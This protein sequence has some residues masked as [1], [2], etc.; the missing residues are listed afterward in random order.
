MTWKTWLSD[1]FF[2][3]SSFRNSRRG[4]RKPK[5]RLQLES[6]EERAL[7]SAILTADKAD[8]RPGATAILTAGGFQVG[9][10]VQFQVV[11]VDG[12]SNAT[13]G[14]APFAI[15]DGGAGDRDGQ[16]NGR[17]QAS[18]YVNPADSVG[19]TFKATAK[20]LSSGLVA[21]TTF[22]D[23]LETASASNLVININSPGKSITLMGVFADLSPD[24]MDDSDDNPTAIFTIAQPPA[25]SL[26][27][28]SLT[29]TQG[30]M[31]PGVL[32]SDGN[33]T[34]AVVTYVPNPT[35]SSTADSFTFTATAHDDGSPVTSSI[36]TAN[37]TIDPAIGAVA[38][39][40]PQQTFISTQFNT[41]LQARVLN[42]N[43]QPIVGTNVTFTAPATGASA[44]FA[45]GPGIVANGG[46]TYT[47]AT[48]SNGVAT[49]S[50]LTANATTGGP[51]TVTATT[52]AVSG[53]AKF[54]LSNVNIRLQANVP[55]SQRTVV[56][57]PFGTILQVLARD[58]S[59]KAMPNV[60]VTF[61]APAR[62]ASA[63]FAAGPGVLANGGKSYTVLTDGNGLARATAL[64]ANAIAGGPYA[65]SATLGSGVPV[66]FSLTNATGKLLF[67]QQPL[68]SFLGGTAFTVAVQVVDDSLN[69]VNASG[70]T[71]R[72]T[73][74]NGTVLGT[75]RTDAH[76]VATF[77]TLIKLP[78]NYTVKVD[79]LDLTSTPLVDASIT[80]SVFTVKNRYRFGT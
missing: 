21:T 8:Y 28:G 67:K 36:V 58:Q 13:P 54:S 61:N 31:V 22:R 17:I 34:L 65:V 59:G 38:G 6:L 23:S 55:L 64:T 80:S 20:G 32:Q 78:G 76:G 33:T 41:P 69:P 37:I 47:V 43:D 68:A 66:F 77:S 16:K 1:W 45:A 52:A 39:T 7:L 10:T 75:A 26:K 40:T 4:L 70:R 42:S 3:Q 51:Y 53:T 24:D 57:L 30:S 9:E 14:H 19:A 63:T 11:H 56:G 2:T 15:T 71:V 12:R 46:R 60:S 74:S 27:F 72:L 50:A 49:A 62:G 73:L 79:L 5:T 48:N 44:T 18:W 35:S 25:G 29:L